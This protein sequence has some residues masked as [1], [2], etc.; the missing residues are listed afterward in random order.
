MGDPTPTTVKPDQRYLSVA[1]TA[2]Y[3]GISERL[4]RG[5]IATGELPT[6]KIR[7]RVLVPRSSITALEERQ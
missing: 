5:M 1:Q 4:V 6:L 3:F 7:S 2:D